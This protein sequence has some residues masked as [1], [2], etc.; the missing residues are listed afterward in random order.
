[1]D[2]NAS[3]NHKRRRESGA[4]TPHNKART[5]TAAESRGKALRVMSSRLG[6]SGTP[7]LRAIQRRPLHPLLDVVR[8]AKGI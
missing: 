2:T 6:G 3:G 7:S 4:G 1:M 8:N 5:A